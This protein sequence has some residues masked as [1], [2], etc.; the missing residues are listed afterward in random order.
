MCGWL[1]CCQR[2]MATRPARVRRT[3]AASRPRPAVTGSRPRALKRWR[4][5]RVKTFPACSNTAVFSREF[6]DFCPGK[7]LDAFVAKGLL[8]DGAG[9]GRMVAQD[10]LA[11]LE[12][13][14][15]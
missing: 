7:K 5:R 13:D 10:M 14:D 6:L 4:A 9:L 3:P 15:A 8:Y 1:V 11:A 12:K 2:L